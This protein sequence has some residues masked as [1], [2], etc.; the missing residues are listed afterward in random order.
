M[1]R[2]LE[3]KLTVG[4]AEAKAILTGAGEGIEL[5]GLDGILIAFG[6]RSEVWL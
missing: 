3:S 6:S 4:G 5:G 2:G 1:T